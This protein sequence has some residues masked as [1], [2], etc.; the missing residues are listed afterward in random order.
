MK[1]LSNEANQARMIIISENERRRR[2]ERIPTLVNYTLINQ[3]NAPKANSAAIVYTDPQVFLIMM[4]RR[5][6]C[7]KVQ[8]AFSRYDLPVT[9]VCHWAEKKQQEKE[10][11]RTQASRTWALSQRVSIER[12]A[13]QVCKRSDNYKWNTAEKHERVGEE[14][15]TENSPCSASF[16]QSVSK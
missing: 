16:K 6:L 8:F 13:R 14:E 15:A 4:P 12:K 5:P 2:A 7:F 10:A 9:C 11:I 3:V 1:R